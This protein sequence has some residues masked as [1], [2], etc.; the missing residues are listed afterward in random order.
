MTALATTVDV[1][2]QHEYVPFPVSHF[3]FSISIYVSIPASTHP[4]PTQ[5]PNDK[6]HQQAAEEGEKEGARKEKEKRLLRKE[7]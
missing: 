7:K 5:I 4:D 3:P 1:D 6:T 2:G